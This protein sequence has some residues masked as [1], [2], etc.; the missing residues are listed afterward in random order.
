MQWLLIAFAA[1]TGMLNTIQSGSNTTLNKALATPLWSAACVFLVALG[2]TVTAALVSGQRFPAGAV[3]QVP[4]WG[5]IGG[6]FGSL[7]ILSMMM[8]ADKVGAA[9]FMAVTVTM[10]IITSLVMDHF[11]LMGFEVHRAGLGRIMGGLAI[12]AGL[13]L[14][15]KF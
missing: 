7:Y 11:G 1:F 3:G 14:I 5:W 4:W 8:V 13:G 15:A 12:I 6:V 2:T 10:A 9:I